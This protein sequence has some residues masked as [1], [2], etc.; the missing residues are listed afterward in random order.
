MEDSRGKQWKILRFIYI[1]S[2]FFIVIKKLVKTFIYYLNI[3]V[4][5]TY[6]ILIIFIFTRIH[7][8]LQLF[9]IMLIIATF[10]K[11]NILNYI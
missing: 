6:S 5:S 1:I 10:E 9:L 2:I 7:H 8:H 4:T 11:Y 3:S